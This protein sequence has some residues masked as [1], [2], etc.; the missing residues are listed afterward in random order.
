VFS[1]SRRGA[2]G[3]PTDRMLRN[4]RF[5][6]TYRC[7]KFKKKFLNRFTFEDGADR[8]SWNVGKRLQIYVA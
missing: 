2:K 8:S 7:K 3:L 5:G 4:R 6:T 1:D